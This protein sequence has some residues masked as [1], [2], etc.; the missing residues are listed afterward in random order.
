MEAKAK[1]LIKV[2]E[3]ATR[4]AKAVIQLIEVVTKKK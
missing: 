1:D 4:T 2:V 3:T